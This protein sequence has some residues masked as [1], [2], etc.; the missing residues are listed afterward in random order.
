VRVYG[1][2]EGLSTFQDYRFIK[3]DEHLGNSGEHPLRLRGAPEERIC[4]SFEAH[5]DSQAASR[6]ACL[7]SLS[8]LYWCQ[9]I[10]RREAKS[11]LTIPIVG[12]T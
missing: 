11:Y 12:P 8:G 10:R 2:L 1:D 5:L 6:F 4:R 3:N 7:I 9:T